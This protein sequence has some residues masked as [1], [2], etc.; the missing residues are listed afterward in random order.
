MLS[1]DQFMVLLKKYS[2]RVKDEKRLKMIFNLIDDDQQGTIDQNN[3]SLLA[4]EVGMPMR[5]KEVK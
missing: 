4:D 2:S 1:F 3:W 5:N